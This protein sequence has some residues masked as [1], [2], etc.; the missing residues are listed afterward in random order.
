MGSGMRG[1]ISEQ[2]ISQNEIATRVKALGKQINE[3]YEGR[4]ITAVCLLKGS[5]VFCSDLVRHINVPLTIDMMRASS[6]GAETKSS[7]SV[8]IHQDLDRDISGHDVLIIEDIIDTGR[9]LHKIIELLSLRNPKSLKICTLLDKPS[10]REV[11]VPINY[12]GF[13]IE[14]RFVIGYGLDFDEYYR[15][16]PYI[17]V[18]DLKGS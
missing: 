13:T 17:G 4:T 2:L 12:T 8:R 7:G 14:D 3:D 18:L 10:R 5:L 6:Y 1:T 16:L 9:T 11:Y 15:N